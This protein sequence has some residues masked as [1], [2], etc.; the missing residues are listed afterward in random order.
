MSDI[1]PMEPARWHS[2][3]RLLEDGRDVAGE[4]RPLAPLRPRDTDGA[5]EGH[6]GQ[7]DGDTKWCGLEA[8][9]SGPPLGRV[10]MI[11]Q[12]PGQTQPGHAA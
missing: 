9:A 10:G 4:R 6:E 12:S 5:D 11:T 7:R 8:G 1:G 2:W 3:H